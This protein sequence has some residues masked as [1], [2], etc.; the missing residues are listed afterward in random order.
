MGTK[1][2][3]APPGEREKRKDKQT[4]KT[5]KL[6][7]LGLVFWIGRLRSNQPL[8]FSSR[9]CWTAHKHQKFRKGIN[10]CLAG[11]KLNLGRLW[12]FSHVKEGSETAWW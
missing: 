12:A 3:Q 1:D 2:T 11:L 9:R 4:D 10:L 8:L 7:L 6:S 5:E